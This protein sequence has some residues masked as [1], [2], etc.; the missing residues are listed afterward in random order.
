MIDLQPAI[1]THI[2]NDVTISSLLSTYQNQKSVFTR[3]PTPQD[4]T[5]PLVIVSPIVGENENDYIGCNGR[6]TL[7]YD[8]AVYS[9]NDE[10][11]NYRNVEKIAFRLTQIF[12]RMDRFALTPPSGSIV[13]V[14]ASSPFPGPTDDF[15]KVARIVTL[16][17]EILL[18]NL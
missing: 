2:L 11:L 1:R 18:E 16:N 13:Q 4:A 15:V 5:Y 12:H 9:N 14:T 17:I 7:T 6:R 8:I 3:R 10:A